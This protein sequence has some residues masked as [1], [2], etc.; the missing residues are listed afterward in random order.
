MSKSKV[1]CPRKAAYARLFHQ[2]V[3]L[4]ADLVD[5]QGPAPRRWW[6]PEIALEVVHK[7]S[8]ETIRQIQP[9]SAVKRLR[10]RWDE[11]G[12]DG[13]LAVRERRARARAATA[14]P[15][16]RGGLGYPVE[17]L[18]RLPVNLAS[19]DV[20]RQIAAEVRGAMPPTVR[21]V[22][23]AYRCAAAE[24]RKRNELPRGLMAA[25]EAHQR[26]MATLAP[27]LRMEEEFR[28][29]LRLRCPTPVW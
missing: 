10:E 4:C 6:S 15:S 11:A 5:V 16:V 24:V 19:Q 20:A 23:E 7:S 29:M 18:A 8:D 3:E 28:Q 21:A 13:V 17:R 12:D 25:V 1:G 26:A 9:R 14:A 27:T 22:E 2:L